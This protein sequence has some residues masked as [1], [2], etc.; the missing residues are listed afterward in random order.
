MISDHMKRV[1]LGERAMFPSAGVKL[2]DDELTRMEA[3]RAA[4]A[5]VWAFVDGL[6]NSR[7]LSI[8][9]THL[10]DAC[11][12]CTRHISEQAATRAGLA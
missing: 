7:E 1:E 11:M 12:R 10:E 6:G 2:S 9:K 5:H 8:A 3:A 4:F